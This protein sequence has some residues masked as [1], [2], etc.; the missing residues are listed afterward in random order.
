MTELAA[1][2]PPI[3]LGAA[4]F[5]L[6]RLILCVFAIAVGL[7]VGQWPFYSHYHGFFAVAAVLLLTELLSEIKTIQSHPQLA[8][9][10]RLGH[11]RIRQLLI[12]VIVG[13]FIVVCGQ[14]YLGQALDSNGDSRQRAVWLGRTWFSAWN[15]APEAMLQVAIFASLMLGAL[16]R[17][18]T[19][20]SSLALLAGVIWAGILIYEFGTIVLLVQIAVESVEASSTGVQFGP[21]SQYATDSGTMYAGVDQNTQQRG[22][23]FVS[24][25]LIGMAVFLI[26]TASAL[27]IAV[28]KQQGRG[29][30][31]KLFM[32][33][34]LSVAAAYPIW[35]YCSGLRQ[36]CPPYAEAGIDGGVIPLLCGFVAAVVV[37]VL[38]A[39][40]TTVPTKDLDANTVA[41]LPRIHITTLVAILMS[42]LAWLGLFDLNVIKQIASLWSWG[43]IAE[44][45]L[46]STNCYIALATVIVIATELYR[47]AFLLDLPPRVISHT[48]PASMRVAFTGF[49]GVIL[50]AAPTVLWLSYALRIWLMTS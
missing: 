3:K 50:I 28:R 16:R 41:T 7:A 14:H 32:V 5:S 42:S 44:N 18:A 1:Q 23:T 4:K 6:R 29:G 43:E 17:N 20:W 27:W 13:F 21:I 46:L 15:N 36:L 37:A 30:R 35:V 11:T 12:L 49:L 38:I 19:R 48:K 2:S 39:Y 25:S 24:R 8:S 34:L 31:K 40:R 47:R 9:H 33:G 10:D 26:C 22:L 45:F